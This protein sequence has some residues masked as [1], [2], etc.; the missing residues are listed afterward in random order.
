MRSEFPIHPVICLRLYATGY[1]AQESVL[2][3]HFTLNVNRKQHRYYAQACER[4]TM[5]SYVRHPRCVLYNSKELGMLTLNV[6]HNY[7]CFYYKEFTTT[8]CFG[9][10]CG[11]SSGC[12]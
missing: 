6:E 4:Q 8:T 3:L 10:I 2:C 5:N 1:L 7:I 9:P 12:G 11:P